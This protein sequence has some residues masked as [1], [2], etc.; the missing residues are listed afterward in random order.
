[1]TQNVINLN[2]NGTNNVL[3]DSVIDECIAEI[4]GHVGDV[5]AKHSVSLSDEFAQDMAIAMRFV[6]AGFARQFGQ[7]T[8]AIQEEM[9]KL[10]KFM[11][12]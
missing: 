4:V 6:R 5:A 8:D 7:N 1:M 2:P 9:T 3:E 11:L 12:K 10:A